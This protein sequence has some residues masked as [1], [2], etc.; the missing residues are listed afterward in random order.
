MSHLVLSRIVIETQSPLA[1]SSGGHDLGS[2]SDVA[3]DW[4]GV[5]CIPAASLMGVW[6]ASAR[7]SGMK[8]SWDRWFGCVNGQ[9][10]GRASRI[11]LS[12]GLLLDTAGDA[13]RGLVP[14]CELEKNLFTR[15]NSPLIIRRQRTRINHRGAA[16]AAGHGKFDTKCLMKGARFVFDIKAFTDDAAGFSAADLN[17]IISLIGEA[18]FAVG[19]GRTSGFGRVAVKGFIQE[20]IDLGEG[21][22]ACLKRI[23][24][25]R[26]RKPPHEIQKGVPG[27]SFNADRIPER[28]QLLLDMKMNV[29]GLYTAGTGGDFL[30]S[31]LKM[32][33]PGK[34]GK[35]VAHPGSETAVVWDGCLGRIDSTDKLRAFIL[36]GSEI[37]GIIAHRMAYHYNR[38]AE[39]WADTALALGG[40]G[41]EMPEPLQVLLF[42]RA[43]DG[44]EKASSANG[45]LSGKL[46]FSDAVV[47]YRKCAA[48]KHNRIDR[49]TGGV[50]DK[51]LF[52]EELAVS[53]VFD[54]RIYISRDTLDIL[55]G[56]VSH[57]RYDEETVSRVVTALRRTFFDL[58]RGL[59]PLGAK[60]GRTLA[61]FSGSKKACAE[62]VECCFPQPEKNG[63]K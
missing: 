1:L 61:E 13:R 27:I 33:F 10:P 52:T 34:M 41:A 62:L 17:A 54:V 7:S 39:N 50:I 5:P 21:G 19:G 16:D 43:G 23:T 31:R 45:A 26:T 32:S 22:A 6:R 58:A 8:D 9:E 44:A 38:L 30:D 46:F 48:R 20:N 4:N 3:Q 63:K 18:S 24:A 11:V 28:F 53:P 36:P 42:G 49:I 12:D 25:F 59:L 29:S 60:S 14:K 15:E 35:S 37:K 2:S 40:K 57:A 55:S 51:A 47:S 56:K